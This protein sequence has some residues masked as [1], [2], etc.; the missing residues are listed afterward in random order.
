MVDP[1]HPAGVTLLMRVPRVPLLL[2][3]LTLIALG[4]VADTWDVSGA[5]CDEPAHLAAGMEWL[6]RGV[7]RYDEMH[8]PLARV[9]VALGPYADGLRSEGKPGIWIEGNAILNQRGQ[10]ERALALARAGTLPFLLVAIVLVFLW[11]RS[12]ANDTAGLLAVLAFTCVPPVLGH[13]G[14][15]T[16]DAAAMTT[17]AG[18]VFVMVRWLERPGLANTCWLGL[19]AGLALL[20]SMSA[21]AF[22]PAAGAAVLLT[23]ASSGRP[24]GPYMGRAGAA[25]VIMVLILWAGYRFSLGP[26]H[27]GRTDAARV[28]AA[29]AKR[30]EPAAFKGQLAA[31]GRLPIYPAPEYPR[32]ILLRRRENRQAGRSDLPGEPIQGGRWYSLPIALAVKTPIPF[33]LLAAVGGATLLGMARERR[34]AAVPLVA[35]AA[36][37]PTAMA[38]GGNSGIGHILPIFPLLAVCAGLG[39]LRLWHWRRLRYAGPAAAIVLAGW[40]V[41]ESARAHPD[42]LPYFNQLVKLTPVA[43][44]GHSVL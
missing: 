35:A 10:P 41:L 3:L 44:V 18:T 14:L 39:I 5:T 26:I 16:T 30:A 7:Y 20:A 8:P 13:S 23:W 19:A 22:L 40:L 11:S 1:A 34:S 15:A 25:G 9:A 6:D 33:L 43:R 4:R 37:F 17:V 24:V 2:A 29:T 31:L 38:T 42:Y 21:L 27:R 36:M 28:A 12:V 32:G